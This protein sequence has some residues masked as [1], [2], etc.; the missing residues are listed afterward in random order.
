MGHKISHGYVMLNSRIIIV[1]PR[2]QSIS[3]QQLQTEQFCC[4]FP[5]DPSNHK[6]ELQCSGNKTLS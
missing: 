3:G 6:N 4:L 2:K 1:K 5:T